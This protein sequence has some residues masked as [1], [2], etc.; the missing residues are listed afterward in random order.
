[1]YTH[2]VIYIKTWEI[3]HCFDMTIWAFSSCDKF[4]LYV[5]CLFA[6][7][8]ERDILLITHIVVIILFLKINV[9]T[10]FLSEFWFNFIAGLFKPADSLSVISKL[11]NTLKKLRQN[12]VL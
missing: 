2:V 7:V 4:V 5:F 1:M 6:L 9:L 12:A 11:E 3:Y 8:I 10:K